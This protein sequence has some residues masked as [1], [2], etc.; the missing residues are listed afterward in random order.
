MTSTFDGQLHRLYATGERL[1]QMYK[2]HEG[3]HSP[4]NGEKW[5]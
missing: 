4:P 5:S 2:R 1:L 3:A